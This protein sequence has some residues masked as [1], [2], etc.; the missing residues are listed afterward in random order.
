MINAYV[1]Y[2]LEDNEK[3]TVKQF[4]QS[5]IVGLLGAS[6]TS[7]MERNRSRTSKDRAEAS[8]SQHKTTVAPEVRRDQSKHMPEFGPSMRRC[9]MFITRKKPPRTR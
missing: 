9:N 1:T 6:T 4:K 5:I 7:S 8:I 3:I 2:T